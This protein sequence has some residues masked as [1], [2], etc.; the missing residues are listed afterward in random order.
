MEPGDEVFLKEGFGRHIVGDGVGKVG[1]DGV[2]GVP[3]LLTGYSKIKI[4]H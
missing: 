1:Q 2:H 4:K 3:G